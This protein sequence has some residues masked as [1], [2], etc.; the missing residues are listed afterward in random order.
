MT[1]DEIMHSMSHI[2]TKSH[3]FT[4]PQSHIA[5]LSNRRSNICNSYLY[6]IM[7]NQR[8]LICDIRDLTPYLQLVK[9]E[10]I[11]AQ[12]ANM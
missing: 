6:V 10:F 7:I 1:S 11:K 3:I 5:F 9:C 4:K 2:N 12:F 8:S